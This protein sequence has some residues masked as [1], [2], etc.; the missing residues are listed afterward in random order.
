MSNEMSVAVSLTTEL[1][2]LRTHKVRYCLFLLKA[3]ETKTILLFFYENL[4]FR[5]N[6][7]ITSLIQDRRIESNTMTTIRVNMVQRQY[8]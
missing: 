5:E 8:I 3:V 4:G 6:L 1:F 2:Y 7:V